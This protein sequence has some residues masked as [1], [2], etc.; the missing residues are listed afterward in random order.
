M[1]HERLKKTLEVDLTFEVDMKFEINLKF[2]VDKCDRCP[3]C[4]I[5]TN[6]FAVCLGEIF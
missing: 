1:Y 3:F 4:V 2:V 6:V 5:D